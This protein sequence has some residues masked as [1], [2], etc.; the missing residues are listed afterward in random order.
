MIIIIVGAREAAH[1]DA[2][3]RRALAVPAAE[4]R[5]VV[6]AGDAGEA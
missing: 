2:H 5:A 4:V 6:L 3:A 1:A